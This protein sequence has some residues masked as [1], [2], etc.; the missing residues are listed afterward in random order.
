MTEIGY[1]RLI[2]VIS[3]AYN[4]KAAV[5]DESDAE[6][7]TSVLDFD[8]LHEQLV[9]LSGRERQVYWLVKRIF[10]IVFSIIALICLSP[11]FLIL[12][13][14]IYVDDPHGSPIYPQTRVGRKGKL[15]RF[16]KFRTMVVGADQMLA[17][18][19]GYNEKDGPVFKIKNDPRITRV[20]KFLRRT[21]LDELPQFWNVLKGDMSLVGPRP[22]LPEEV[23]QYSRYQKERLLV[24]PGL[25][26]YWQT[27]HN[28]DQI[29]FDDWVDMDIQYILNRSFLLDLKLILLTVKVVLTGEGE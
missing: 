29:S 8:Q 23:E 3:P 16:Y 17:D 11:V 13:I 2:G 20:G 28:R 19:Q 14:L 7:A 5:L 10:D 18:L 4:N 6:H 12:A 27:K 22:A 9:R 15:F 1:E 21:S 24:T 26:C 25:T